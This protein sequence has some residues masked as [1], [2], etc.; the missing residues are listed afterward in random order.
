MEKVLIILYAPLE[1][2]KISVLVPEDE[3]FYSFDYKL[4]GLMKLPLEYSNGD[5]IRYVFQQVETGE[6][7]DYK[8]PLGKYNV[9]KY[10]EFRII[11]KIL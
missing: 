5:K 8:N 1:K 4:L 9:K 2:E 7:V 3:P 11:P 10:N 6:I